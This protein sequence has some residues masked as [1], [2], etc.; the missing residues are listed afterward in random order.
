MLLLVYFSFLNLFI[1]VQLVILLYHP[2]L[3]RLVLVVSF[4]YPVNVIHFAASAFDLSKKCGS[5]FETNHKIF[6]SQVLLPLKRPV[7][8]CL[9]SGHQHS[10]SNVRCSGLACRDPFDAFQHFR[11][12]I[13]SYI[14][15]LF[16]QFVVLFLLLNE[17]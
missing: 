17:M 7:S 5:M 3:R 8:A 9:W 2:F 10:L 6:I 13:F 11:N 14:M 16:S 12:H 15:W 4:L 1:L